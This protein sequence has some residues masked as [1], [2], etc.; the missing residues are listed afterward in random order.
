M[1]VV[2][3]MSGGVDSSVAALELVEAGHEVVGLSMQLYDQQQGARR[4]SAGAARSTTCTTRARTAAALGIPHYVMNFE[5][6]FE[7]AVVSVF[8]RE[9][10]AGR[11]SLRTVQ[12]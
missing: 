6:Q 5:R 12:R 4:G 2:V 3:A 1:R 8:V 9:Y 7:A 10:A 11:D